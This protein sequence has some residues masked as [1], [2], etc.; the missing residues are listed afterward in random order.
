MIH[1]LQSASTEIDEAVGFIYRCIYIQTENSKMHNHDYYEIFLTLSKKV[2][3]D[4]NGTHQTLPRGTLVFIRKDDVHCYF[5]T[6]TNEPSFVNL[7]FTEEILNELFQFLSEGFCSKELLDT[8]MPPSVQL[9][10]SDIDWIIQQTEMLNSTIIN[11]I[12]TLKYRSRVLLFKI[13]TRYFSNFTE[14]SRFKEDSAIPQWLLKLDHEMHKPENFCQNAEHMV[15]MSGKCRAYLGRVLK[16]YYN[17]TIPDYINDLRLNYWA[18]SL[19]NTDAPILDLCFEC[20]FENVSWAY[21][22]F[23]KKY[24]VSPLKFRK[25]G[26]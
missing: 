19:V 22:L 17:K 15:E 11:D 7:A 26:T 13:F 4:I 6:T 16:L 9:Y 18:N 2:Y 1:V 10:E 24:G 14:H 3:H 20:G 8:Q 5:S 25:I 12:P 23:K 21:T